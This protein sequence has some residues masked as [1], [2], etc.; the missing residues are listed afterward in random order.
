MKS[1]Y[2]YYSDKP[3]NISNLLLHWQYLILILWLRPKSILEIGCG[4]AQ[5]SLFIKKL[6]PKTS[7]F[8]L[9]KDKKILQNIPDKD[10]H[11]IEADVLKIQPPADL[12]ISQGLLEHF[13]DNQIIK[14]VKNFRGKTKMILSSVPSDNYPVKDFGNEILRNEKAYRDILGRVPDIRFSVIG[15]IDLGWR[16][17]ML[18]IKINKLDLF[19]SLEYI[20]FRPNHLLIIIEYI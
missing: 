10:I 4:P 6:L 16:T 19:S 7:I 3:Y 1:W 14:L 9:D 20:F 8:L 17:K 11:K 18:G 15:Y 5:H 13:T 12:V 2:T